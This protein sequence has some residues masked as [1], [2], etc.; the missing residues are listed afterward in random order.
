MLTL[1]FHTSREIFQ[2]CFALCCSYQAKISQVIRSF[3]ICEKFPSLLYLLVFFPDIS[4]SCDR[5]FVFRFWAH[6]RYR[7][8]KCI[9]RKEKGTVTKGKSLLAGGLEFFP[10]NSSHREN[11]QT[12]YVYIDK[13]LQKICCSFFKALSIIK[14]FR[15]T[16][17][18]S[19]QSNR[20]TIIGLRFYLTFQ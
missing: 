4:R 7:S 16:I 10:Q 15:L 1:P 3:F 2:F 19:T 17:H 13:S 9:S 14:V 6:T 12:N 5:K 8:R 18:D 20:K 11:S